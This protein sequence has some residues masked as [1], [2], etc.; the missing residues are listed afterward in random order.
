MLYVDNDTD[1]QRKICKDKACK[2]IDI[3]APVA[4]TLNR[5][6]WKNVTEQ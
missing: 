6:M 2:D 4:L 3:T 1:G 5:L